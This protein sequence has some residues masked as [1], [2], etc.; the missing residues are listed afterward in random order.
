MSMGVKEK[1]EKFFVS[2]PTKVY[3]KGELLIRPGDGPRAYYVSEG[4]VAQYDISTSGDK[5][6]V[7][8][9]KSGAFLPISTII[10]NVAE[11]FFFEATGRVVVQIAPCEATADFL[12]QNSDVTLDA[13][14]RMSRGASGLMMRLARVMEGGADGRVVLE[15][16][17]MQARFGS[18]GGI[19][20]T[21]AQLAAQTG[22]AR[23]TVSR[24]LKRLKN[25]GILETK[26]GRIMLKK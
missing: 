12:A 8:L 18:E 14:K 24:T 26:R 5:L 22:L 16:E 2:Y 23:E 11:E 1:V 21:E 7:N 25:N 13:L 6:V 4:V 9:Y 19:A 10:N 17:I 3:E 15:L 20:I